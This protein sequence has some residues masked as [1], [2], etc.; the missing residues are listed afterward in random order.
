MRSE[1]MSA[2]I[3]REDLD[4]FVVMEAEMRVIYQ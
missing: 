4:H 1:M 3:G 2:I